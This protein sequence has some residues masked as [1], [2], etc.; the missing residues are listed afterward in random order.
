[1]GL[2]DRNSSR[3]TQQTNIREDT[4]INTDNR[5]ATNGSTQL[6]PVG[7]SVSI[8][9]GSGQ[10][11]SLAAQTVESNDRLTRDVITG[12]GT[13]AVDLVKGNQEFVGKVAEQ[14]LDLAERGFESQEKNL[15]RSLDFG[16][17]AIGAVQQTGREAVGFLTQ[18]TDNV[19][20]RDAIQKIS[21]RTDAGLNEALRAVETVGTVGSQENEQTRTLSM[22]AIAGIVAV[23]GIIFIVV[24]NRKK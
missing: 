23:G 21:E 4:R 24:K 5:I 7:G 17:Q 3:T 19:L 20:S 16:S 6:G 13:A 18:L 2:F 10:V 11:L 14:G 12:V 15:D 22:A 1:M 9:D 8:N